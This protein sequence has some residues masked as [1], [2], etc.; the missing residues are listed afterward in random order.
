MKKYVL[1]IVQNSTD[2][3]SPLIGQSFKK[4]KIREIYPEVYVCESS[5]S[6]VEEMVALTFAIQAVADEHTWFAHSIENIYL[7]DLKTH[8]KIELMFLVE[9]IMR[10]T[11]EKTTDHAAITQTQEAPTP[12]PTPTAAQPEP[13]AEKKTVPAPVT[14]AKPTPK[15]EEK[16]ENKY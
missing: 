12:A 2:D 16:T 3:I 15:T 4:H 13:E 9:K 7:Y 8:Q 14:N 11:A 1:V 6:P 10:K 5:T